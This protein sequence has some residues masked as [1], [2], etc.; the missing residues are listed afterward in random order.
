M[1]AS[2]LDVYGRQLVA[3][4]RCWSHDGGDMMHGHGYN[5]DP[6]TPNGQPTRLPNPA[7]E[8]NHRQQLLAALQSRQQQPVY[9][10]R[11]ARYVNQAPQYTT[12]R[13]DGEAAERAIAMLLIV[14]VYLGR[15]IYRGVWWSVMAIQARRASRPY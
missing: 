1:V 9:E 12:S 10:D 3:A 8:Y 7:A 13:A 14:L 4:R 5:Y 6:L 15:G 2:K 11:T